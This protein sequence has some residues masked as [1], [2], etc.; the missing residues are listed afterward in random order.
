[1][2]FWLGEPFP[3]EV[4]PVPLTHTGTSLCYVVS[5]SQGTSGIVSPAM[6]QDVMS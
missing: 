3:H 4:L 6:I 2:C 1:M 5:G